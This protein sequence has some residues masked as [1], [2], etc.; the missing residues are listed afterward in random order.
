[1]CLAVPTLVLSIRGKE[2]EVELGGVRRTVSVVLT[3]EVQVHDYVLIHAGFAINVI[4]EQE[5]QET[6]RL[7][8]ELDEFTARM[9]AE[10]PS[11]TR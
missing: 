8:R 11:E 6:L 3:P 9:E 10:S 7:F 2:A 5:A 4:D 1:M